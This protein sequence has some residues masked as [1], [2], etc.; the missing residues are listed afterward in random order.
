MQ[1][2]PFLQWAGGKRQLISDIDKKISKCTFTK[3]AEPFVGGGA[4]LFHVLNNYP[5]KE[6]WISDTNETLISTYKIIRDNP[7]LLITK[8]EEIQ[9]DFLSVK[10]EDRKAFYLQTREMFNVK[11]L[12]DV[13]KAALFIFLNHTCFNGLYRV[14]KKGYFNVPMGTYKNPII[15][16]AENILG[17][18]K[19][20]KNAEIQCCDYSKSENFITKDTLVYLDP[21]Y[22][23]L[24]ITSSF[25]AYGQNGFSDENQKELAQ[26]VRKIDSIGA[27]FILS[28]SNPKNFNPED[29][30][31]EDLYKGF[32]IEEVFAKRSINCVATKRNKISELLISNIGGDKI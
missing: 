8:L 9:N 20:L 5:V 32:E 22:R 11:Q 7:S 4:V 30:F 15:Y 28:N 2:K 27:N 31:F 19:L 6:V 17:V 3:Y 21:P 1:S 24:N 23:P 25:T 29:T 26:F 14:N 18:S 10:S 12:S 13:D 16:N